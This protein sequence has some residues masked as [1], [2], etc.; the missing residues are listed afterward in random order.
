METTSPEARCFYGFQIAIE[1]IHSEVY[2]LLIDTY[3]KDQAEKDRL[4]N[5]IQTIECV[6]KKAKWALQW[7]NREYASFQERLIA[8][9]AVEGIFFSGSFCAIFWMKKRGLMPGLCFSNELISRDEGLHTDFAC[10]LYNKMVNKL[11][12]ERITEIIVDALNIECEFI[13][14]A[15]PVELIGM[16]SALMTQYL[17]FVA[18]RL[19]LAL[20]APKHYNVTNPFDWMDLISLSGKTNFFEKRVGEY[21]I[22]GVGVDAEQQKFTLDADF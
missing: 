19:L 17:Q 13:R 9:A 15:L 1:N 6:E 20:G 8:F 16:N 12:A 14:D 10:M 2:S 22:S 5:A 7:C 3:I 18:D 11:P 21:S 4:F